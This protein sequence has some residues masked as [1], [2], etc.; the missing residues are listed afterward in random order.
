MAFWD[1]NMV[2][3]KRLDAKVFL[4][5]THL[6]PSFPFSFRC[7]DEEFY[8]FLDVELL[9]STLFMIKSTHMRTNTWHLSRM[10]KLVAWIMFQALSLLDDSLT[11]IQLVKIYVWQEIRDLNLWTLHVE[12]FHFMIV[13]SRVWLYSHTLLGVGLFHLNLEGLLVHTCYSTN[14]AI[15]NPIQ[16]KRETTFVIV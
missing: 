13:I 4:F 3:F 5:S 1:L 2:S 14:S 11:V 6:L 9:C 10:E 7:W 16:I 12:L 8:H 15:R